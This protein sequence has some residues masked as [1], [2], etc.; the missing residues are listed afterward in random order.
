MVNQRNLWTEPL[1]A[2]LVSCYCIIPVWLAYHCK[3]DLW[4]YWRV[5]KLVIKSAS[6]R[7]SGTIYSPSVLILLPVICLS[8]L[9]HLAI[10]EGDSLV[11][12][13]EMFKFAFFEPRVTSW[14]FS[15]V[16]SGVAFRLGI[17]SLV[18]FSGLFLQNKPIKVF[19]KQ[20]VR[21]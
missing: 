7:D 4:L 18:L 6:G 9:K 19:K 20:S 3:S 10:Y 14:S 5:V 2:A 15:G 21:R 17:F 13:F 11:R 8:Y 16:L 12:K 1:T